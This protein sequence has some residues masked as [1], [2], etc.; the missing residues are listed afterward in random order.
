[1][2]N[3]LV[4]FDV[5][6]TIADLHSAWVYQYNKITGNHNRPDDITE[7]YVPAI[8]SDLTQEQ[9]VEIIS[10]PGIYQR[11]RPYQGAL[12][13]VDSFREHYTIGFVSDCFP[14]NVQAKYEWLVDNLFLTR[15]DF[16]IS[17]NSQQ[18]SL[19]HCEALFDDRVDSVQNANYGWLVDRP[20]N[21]HTPFLRRVAT[22][23]YHGY[24]SY[25]SNGTE[26]VLPIT[27][28]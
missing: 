22:P 4:L 18:R 2:E 10:D 13:W 23:S 6:G 17:A 5:D 3:N 26:T 28:S 19:I 1:M 15:E 27:T 21:A 16:F 12:A 20:W 14:S 7:W 9:H 11:V 25:Q 24:F 8:L